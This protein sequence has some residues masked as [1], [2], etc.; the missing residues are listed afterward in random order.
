MIPRHKE[1]IDS[2]TILGDM[3]KQLPKFWSERWY[4]YR[5]QAILL[6][7]FLLWTPL[8]VTGTLQVQHSCHPMILFSGE[9]PAECRQSSLIPS[10]FEPSAPSPTLHKNNTYGLSKSPYQ[11]QGDL[12]AGT[13]GIAGAT[14]LAIGGAPVT[15][16][17]GVGILLWLAVRTIF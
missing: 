14:A 15:L 13:V 9:L 2:I 3:F 17:V 5:F 7:C 4:R 6:G 1:T 11:G 12:M 8:L 16:A 10:W